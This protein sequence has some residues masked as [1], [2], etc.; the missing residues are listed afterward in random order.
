MLTVSN[1]WHASQLFLMDEVSLS[2]G[3]FWSVSENTLN[4]KF[5]V[6]ILIY[7][8]HHCDEAS[9]SIILDGRVN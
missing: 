2:I 9:P 1:H 5:K 6:C 4:I 7:F 3:R 8:M